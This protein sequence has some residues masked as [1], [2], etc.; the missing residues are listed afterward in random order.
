MALPG[1]AYF[2]VFKYVPMYGLIMAFQDFKPHLGFMDSPWVGMKHFERFF[3]EDQFWMLF[4]NTALLAV[5]NL[6]FFFPSL[7]ILA[8][9]LNEVRLERYKRFVQT[10]VYIPHFVSWVVVVGIF[11][12]LFTTEGER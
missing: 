8:L 11:Y 2:L 10:L 1:L 9:M 3:S 12:I 6:V 4:R 7:I 5:Y